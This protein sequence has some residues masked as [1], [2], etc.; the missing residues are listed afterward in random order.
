M[1]ISMF[2]R[3]IP[4]VN[5]QAKCQRCGECCGI[6]M[7]N[8]KEYRNIMRYA[9][10]HGILP[11]NEKNPIDCP[12]RHR[13]D[14]RFSCAVYPVRP[15]VCRMF[16]LSESMQCPRGCNSGITKARELELR[17]EYFETHGLPRL[18]LNRIGRDL[19]VENGRVKRR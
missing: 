9:L 12:F 18:L 14:D 13:K 7:C 10:R 2:Y 11:M 19:V 6:I 3:K 17:K 8:D 1:G 4:A 16:G 5:P 15:F